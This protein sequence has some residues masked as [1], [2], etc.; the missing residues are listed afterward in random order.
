MHSRSLAYTTKDWGADFW[1]L[2]WIVLNLKGI[3]EYRDSQATY[4]TPFEYLF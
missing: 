2:A 3:G 1:T 4:S